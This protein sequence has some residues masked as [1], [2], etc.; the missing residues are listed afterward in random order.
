MN[1]EPRK[2][3][4]AMVGKINL[5]SYIESKFN[6]RAKKSILNSLWTLKSVINLMFHLEPYLHQFYLHHFV[7]LKTDKITE[8]RKL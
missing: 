5:Q 4:K 7:Q 1:R 3:S 8:R 6:P 2:L